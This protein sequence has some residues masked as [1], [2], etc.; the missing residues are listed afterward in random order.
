MRK[1][2]VPGSYDPVHN[3]HI[4]VIERASRLFDE[5]VVAAIRNPQK[6]ASLFSLEERRDM[7]AESLAHLPNIRIEFFTGLLVDFASE[8][9]CNA[10]VKGLKEQIREIDAGDFTGASLS[11]GNPREI[12][13]QAEA[14]RLLI[15]AGIPVPMTQ[16]QP[17]IVVKLNP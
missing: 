14:K 11:Y 8:H 3:G 1:A 4:E 5:V 16:T 7:L 6:S 13:D 15:E 9:D 2:L 17:S 12:M 10:I